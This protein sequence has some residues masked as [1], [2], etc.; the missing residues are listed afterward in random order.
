V[1]QAER[2]A[3]VSKGRRFDLV[4]VQDSGERVGIRG[5]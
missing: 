4:V 3:A 2:E 1:Q 5:P